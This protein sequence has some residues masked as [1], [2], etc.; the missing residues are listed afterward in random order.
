MTWKNLRVLKLWH[1][2]YSN[3]FWLSDTILEKHL[4]CFYIA[5]VYCAFC[6][7]FPSPP[8]RR[9]WPNKCIYT[10]MIAFETNYVIYIAMIYNRILTFQT[11]APTPCREVCWAR[12]WIVA[13]TSGL[14]FKYQQKFYLFIIL[15]LYH[16]SSTRRI[17]SEPDLTASGAGRFIHRTTE[18]PRMLLRWHNPSNVYFYL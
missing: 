1:S 10:C 9:V 5:L 2:V 11:E 16:T 17:S 15:L 4:K 7:D 14:I 3:L 18:Y 6:W 8:I 12:I 13:I